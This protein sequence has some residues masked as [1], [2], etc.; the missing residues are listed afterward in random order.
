MSHICKFAR[1]TRG[2]DV[3]GGSNDASG[4]TN[5]TNALSQ[6]INAGYTQGFALNDVAFSPS[7][8]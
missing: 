2:T 6:L 1:S 3:I 4:S 7:N 5:L 8:G